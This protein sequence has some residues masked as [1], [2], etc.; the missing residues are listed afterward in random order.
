M[1]S[2]EQIVDEVVEI[3]ADP[4]LAN[5]TAKQ[6]EDRFQELDDKGQLPI[7]LAAFLTRVIASGKEVDDK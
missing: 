6:A 2:I 1:Q 5:E 3:F 4:H 7:G